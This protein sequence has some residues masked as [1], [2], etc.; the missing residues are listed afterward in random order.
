MERKKEG[1]DREIEIEREKKRKKALKKALISIKATSAI[2]V[3]VEET[4]QADSF[5]S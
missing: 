3:V 5:L 2:A 1:E 4:F